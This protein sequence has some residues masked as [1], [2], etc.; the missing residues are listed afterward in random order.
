MSTAFNYGSKDV[1]L[2]VE[3][4]LDDDRVIDA[5][6]RARLGCIHLLARVNTHAQTLNMS[7]F[8]FYYAF[9]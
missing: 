4:T 1:L 6:E 5:L 2:G 8:V 9:R 3:S 7:L